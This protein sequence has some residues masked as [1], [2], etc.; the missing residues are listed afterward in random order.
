MHDKAISVGEK[1][2]LNGSSIN[3]NNVGTGVASKDGSVVTI[4]NPTISNTRYYK[5]MAYMK[6][7]QY[8]PSQLIINHDESEIIQNKVLSQ[9]ENYL[10]INNKVIM[11]QKTDIDK[12]YKGIMKK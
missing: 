12:L 8:G 10:E 1:S 7:P 11:Q 2:S 4:N 5:Y 6:K 9:T 3:I